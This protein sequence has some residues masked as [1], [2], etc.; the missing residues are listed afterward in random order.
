ML[1]PY[2]SFK[3]RLCVY[4]HLRRWRLEST[5]VHCPG[6]EHEARAR[7]LNHQLH[8]GTTRAVWAAVWKRQRPP[9]Q[10]IYPR[11][12]WIKPPELLKLQWWL[13]DSPTR[14]D[15]AKRS[16]DFQGPSGEHSHDWYSLWF[17]ALY[18]M[19]RHG[20]ERG[21]ERR[22]VELDG[23]GHVDTE[24]GGRAGCRV[25]RKVELSLCARVSLCEWVIVGVCGAWTRVVAN[26]RWPVLFPGGRRG[27]IDPHF[28]SASVWACV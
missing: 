11:C 22:V 3:A 21:R 7:P 16:Q 10:D 25:W 4:F 17:N 8:R 18:G 9:G 2:N 20:R 6:K 15:V 19:A 24:V 28:S 12:P 1:I 13:A 5:R 14:F 27:P 23:G 26:G